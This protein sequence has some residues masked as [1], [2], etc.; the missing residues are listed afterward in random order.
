MRQF[1]AYESFFPKSN[2]L[3]LDVD[4]ELLLQILTRIERTHGSSKGL[5]VTVIRYD[6]GHLNFKVEGDNDFEDRMEAKAEGGALPAAKFNV[7]GLRRGA[8]GAGPVERVKLAFNADPVS[9]LVF[10]SVEAPG[11]RMLTLPMAR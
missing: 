10:T 9:P 6:D 7:E 8:E 2:S 3:S 4:K 5:P 1:P 11:Y